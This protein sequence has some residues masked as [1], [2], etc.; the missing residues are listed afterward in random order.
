MKKISKISIL[1][2][3]VLTLVMVTPLILPTSAITA[4]AATVKLNKSKLTLEKGKTSTLKLSGTSKTVKWK[5]SNN[6]IAKVSS[7]GKIT[8]VS[9]GTAT[10]TATLNGKAYNCKVTVSSIMDD[11]DTLSKE[12]ASQMATGTFD[13]VTEKFN[14][15]MKA[16]LSEAALKQTWDSVVANLGE[17][18]SVYDSAI[19][20]QGDYTILTVRLE[21][22]NSGL[23]VIFVYGTSGLIE[24][25]NINY[26]TIETAPVVSETYEETDILIGSGKYQLKGKLTLPK[27]VINP[28]VIVLV[29]GSGQSDMDE[30]I[31]AAGN[32]PF[33]DIALGLA[34]QGIATIRYNKRYYQ[35]AAF[36]TNSV[37]IKD[38]VLDDVT[39]AITYAKT[40]GKVDPNKIYVLGHSL[41]GMLAPKIALDNKDV[42]GIISL[43]GSPRK[44]EDIMY[45]QSIDVLDNMKDLSEAD[46]QS[47]IAEIS[48]EI[49]KI[50]NAQNTDTVSILGVNSSYWYSLNQINTPEIVKELDIPMLFLQGSD[51]FQVFV[52]TDFAVWQKLLG[53]RDNV[54]FHLYDK[55]N[56]LFMISNGKKDVTEYNTAGHVDKDVISDIA[57]WINK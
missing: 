57:Q 44:L 55:L 37:T 21:Y 2:V 12:L 30:S 49:E 39:N 51:D 11:Y 7:K 42:V 52:D 56:H 40:C 32:K 54:T 38:E 28:P 3:M 19:S 26:T 18:V 31:G 9:E 27:N 34:E 33:R 25:L 43:A 4:E 29:Q 1:L 24:G 47:S 5:S 45:D 36:A 17:F 41:G 46:R 14:A 48:A 53:G 20:T 6:K 13:K 16:E 22:K 15:D 10:I 50:K 8:A 23:Q 35:Y